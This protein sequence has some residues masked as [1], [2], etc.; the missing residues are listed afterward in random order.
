MGKSVVIALE[1]ALP[2]AQGVGG[3]GAVGDGVPHAV[4]LAV[5]WGVRVALCRGVRE[6]SVGENNAEREGS[7]EEEELGEWLA[8][9]EGVSLKVWVGLLVSEA[10]ALG[11]AHLDDVVD[12]LGLAVE[13]EQRVGEGEPLPLPHSEAP[14]LGESVR[15]GEGVEDLQR[16]GVA[17]RLGSAVAEDE[18]EGLEE[19]LGGREGVGVWEARAQAV[20]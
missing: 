5:L 6:A 8:L 9:G 19:A 16:V 11:V 7:R 12:T 3:G 13:E 14:A 2:L 1:L 10:H 17:V 20:G 18:R 4:A 15:L